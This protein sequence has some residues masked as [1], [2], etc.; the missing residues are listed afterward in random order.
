MPTR[1][2]HLPV[3]RQATPGVGA[4]ATPEIVTPDAP[5]IA[6]D[7]ATTA[8]Q[9]AAPAAQP[10]LRRT[11][12]ALGT[13]DFRIFYLG[14]L[15]SVT[16]TWMQTVAQGWLVLLLT[17]SPLL[18]G[19]TQ[20]VRTLPILFLSL[21]AGIVA[22][23]M[24]RRRIILVA[25]VVMLALAA[26]LAGLTLSDNIT[27]E[28]ILVIGAGLG[29]ANAFEMPAR[30]SLVVQLTG[31]RLLANAI[32]LNS[33]LFNT[34]RVVG[35]ALA[36]LIVALA[37]VGVAFALNAFTFIPVILSLLMITPRPVEQATARM[38]GAMGETITYLRAQ[39]VVAM[40]LALLGANTILA[41]GYLFLGPALA[42]DLGQGAE[43]LGLI[44]SAAGVGAVAALAGR[45]G[46]ARVLVAG[47]LILAVALVLVAFSSWFPVTLA[48]MLAVGWGTVTYSATSNTVIQTI[49]PDV[50]RGRIMSLYTI[51]MVGLM[52]ISGLF[53]GFLAD[54]L[55]TAAAMGIGGVLWGL[56]A[57]TAFGVS[58][59]MRRL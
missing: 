2:V 3:G 56:I 57:V 34:A 19:V 52:P 20:A 31:R 24:D 46:L 39:P 38:R 8:P 26:I 10:L 28:A 25:D 11:F 35:P 59:R 5:A 12:E 42:R 6:P 43:G 50:L 44:L 47:A 30:Q 51:V 41:S 58:A 32:A 27:V 23:R 1:P 40:L 15:I 9:A 29:I 33:L 16:G 17:G 18:L 14:Q 36:G 54:R 48:L 37:G 49:V 22:D 21:P 4:G 7:L 55:G 45:R 53:L 13:R